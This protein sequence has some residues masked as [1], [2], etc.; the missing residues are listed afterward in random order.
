MIDV[1]I[2]NKT[3]FME[4]SKDSIVEVAKVVEGTKNL[5]PN[6]GLVKLESNIIKVGN[7]KFEVKS[8]REG[9]RNYVGM[10][11]GSDDVITF[12]ISIGELGITMCHDDK[13]QVL[14]KVENKEKWAELQK[15]GNVVGK[16]CVFGRMTVKEAMETGNFT[17]CGIR[18]K[19]QATEK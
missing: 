17:R 12:R 13:D 19:E 7:N 2:D 4:L 5:G 1:R 15:R 10:S 16:N 9:K 6:K 14:V 3:V 8:E 11:Y 18:N